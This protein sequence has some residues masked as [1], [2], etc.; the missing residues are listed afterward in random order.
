L[1]YHPRDGEA[2][3]A[4][5]PARRVSTRVRDVSS[6]RVLAYLKNRDAD[7]ARYGEAEIEAKVGARDPRSIAPNMIGARI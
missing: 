2:D 6:V 3:A 4:L 7:G 1:L 5:A